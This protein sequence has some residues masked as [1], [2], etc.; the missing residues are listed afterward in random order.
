M[1]T[2]HDRD[3]SLEQ[4]LS[5]GLPRSGPPTDVC[6]D[7]ETAAA[8]LDG[9][10]DDRAR[11]RTDA[12]VS[13]CARCQALVASVVEL[14][15]AAAAVADPVPSPWRAWLNWMVPLGATAAAGLALI[16]WM[17]APAGPVQRADEALQARVESVPDTASSTPP[18]T[19][20]AEPAPGPAPGLPSQPRTPPDIARKSAAPTGIVGR[21]DGAPPPAALAPAPQVAAGAAA[22]RAANADGAT[23]NAAAAAPPPTTAPAPAAPRARAAADASLAAPQ[24][25]AGNR[26]FA[27]REASGFEVTSPDSPVRWRVTGRAVSRSADGGAVWAPVVPD[28]PGRLLA[29]SASSPRV[30]W[31][32]GEG[33]LVL[34]ALDGVTFVRVTAPAAVDLTVV[35][36]ASAANAVVG[37]ADGR[38]FVTT[39]GGTTWQPAP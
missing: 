5:A 32:V 39:D 37:A 2:P 4:W 12:H 28:A 18:E 31:L 25:A 8:W 16:V 14:E 6:L 13:T 22:E 9:G 21:A 11:Q 17:N 34:R 36:A 38:R 19:V 3:R 29:G 1:T 24:E 15:T 30:C 26:A 35:T 10:L 20:P 27:A 23:A 33:G 7:A